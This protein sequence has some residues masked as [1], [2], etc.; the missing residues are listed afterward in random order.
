VSEFFLEPGLEACGE[1]Q[2]LGVG[3][4]L[5]T[6]IRGLKKYT[7]SVWLMLRLK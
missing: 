3:F 5:H 4:D 1:V 7:E 6:T 2:M